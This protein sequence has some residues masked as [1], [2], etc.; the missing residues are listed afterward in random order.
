VGVSR[1]KNKK[2]CYCCGSDKSRPNAKGSPIW[3]LN[4]DKDEN[5]FC[6]RCYDKLIKNPRNNPNNHA[7]RYTYGKRR[8]L[9]DKGSRTGKCEWCSK[10]IGDTY[11]GWRKRIKII[12]ETHLHHLFYLVICPWF[13]RVEL[14]APC[15]NKESWRERRELIT[16]ERI[17]SFRD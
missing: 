6:C 17:K 3:Y 16:K 1:T 9:E 8:L 5:V 12:K 10:K 14:C 2:I 13:G 7:R 4:Y 15:H 11:I